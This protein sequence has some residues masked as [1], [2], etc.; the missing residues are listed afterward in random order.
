MIVNNQNVY[1][2]E[3]VSLNNFSLYIYI[4]F[5]LVNAK[6]IMLRKMEIV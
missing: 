6:H 3:H 2:R 1:L 5:Y 4:K